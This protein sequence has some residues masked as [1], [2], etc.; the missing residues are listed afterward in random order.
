MRLN[1]VDLQVSDV[2]RAR[3]FFER[4]FGLR[5]V[6]QRRDELAMLEDEAGL[7]LGVS[8]LFHSPAPVYPPD[9]HVGFILETEAQVREQYQRLARAG[10][11]MK[12]DLTVGGPNLYFVCI[13]PD[14][15]PVEVR[16]PRD[17]A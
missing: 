1:H 10:V 12:A 2:D 4:H 16:A 3:E 6:F 15:I 14:A 5:C 13:G 7:S 11:Q 9:F 17:A 8:N